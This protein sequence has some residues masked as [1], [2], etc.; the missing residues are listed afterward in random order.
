MVSNPSQKQ[1]LCACSIQ[2]SLEQQVKEMRIKH[3]VD[4]N[5]QTFH[6]MMKEYFKNEQELCDWVVNVW[7]LS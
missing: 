7:N 6:E 4:R 3:S 2:N 5:S 1:R